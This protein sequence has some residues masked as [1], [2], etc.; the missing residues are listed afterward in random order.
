MCHENGDG[1]PQN[2]QE[3]RRL[4]QLSAAQDPTKTTPAHEALKR[5][6]EKIRTECPLL[7]KRVMIT[8]T[9]REDLN[10]MTAMAASFDH[11]QGRYAVALDKQRGKEL[12][13]RPQ[14]LRLR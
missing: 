12:A 9:S 1:V 13:L 8:G 11:V 10:G 6:N 5:M 3:A 2:Y 7:G 4:Y 14:N